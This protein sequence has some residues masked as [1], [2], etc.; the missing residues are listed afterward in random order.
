[1]RKGGRS[2]EEG[3]KYRLMKREYRK[4]YEEKRKGER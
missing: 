4:L 3:G 2:K 1:M